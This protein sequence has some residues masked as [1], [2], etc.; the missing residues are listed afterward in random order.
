[1][2]KHYGI[3]LKTSTPYHPQGNGMAERSVRKVIQALRI[4]CERKAI[5]DIVLPEIVAMINATSMTSFTSDR[6]EVNGTDV[7]RSYA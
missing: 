1:M 5:W 2:A 3:Q 6:T 4:Y 7:R